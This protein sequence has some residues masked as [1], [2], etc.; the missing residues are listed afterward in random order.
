MIESTIIILSLKYLPEPKENKNNFINYK[1]EYAYSSGQ[2]RKTILQYATTW[3]NLGDKILSE[4][5]QSH[6]STYMR[7]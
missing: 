5:S 6:D 4:M 3:T 2:K 7:F 1:G